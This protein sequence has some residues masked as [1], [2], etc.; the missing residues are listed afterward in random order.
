M[1]WWQILLLLVITLLFLTAATIGGMFIALR[2]FMTVLLNDSNYVRWVE[3][4]DKFKR[5]MRVKGFRAI[6]D[7]LKGS[8]EK[9]Y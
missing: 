4:G 2:L 9:D 7:A 8:R 1:I 6:D 3:A 5:L